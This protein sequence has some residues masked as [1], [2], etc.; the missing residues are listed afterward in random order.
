MKL[1]TTALSIVARDNTVLQA[2]READLRLIKRDAYL[3]LSTLPEDLKRQCRRSSL[4]PETV[5]GPETQQLVD[6]ATGSVRAILTELRPPS[7]RRGHLRGP[8]RQDHQ[9]SSRQTRREPPAP[10]YPRGRGWRG[11]G[12][13]GR[14]RAS[15]TVTSAPGPKKS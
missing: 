4:T 8:G 6:T 9:S 2:V 5:F 13:R 1:V 10:Y 3:K 7:T 15:A 11:R 12:R 14:G